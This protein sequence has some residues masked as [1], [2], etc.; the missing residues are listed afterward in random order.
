MS[1][2]SLDD[3]I[4]H[5]LELNDMSAYTVVVKNINIHGGFIGFLYASVLSLLL[6][7]HR[8]MLNSLKI[9]FSPIYQSS[10][11]KV[12]CILFW[13]MNHGHKS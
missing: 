7:D 8:Q 9:D 1:K 10:C 13:A 12:T 3:N 4:Y 5:V 6:S 11:D 2:N